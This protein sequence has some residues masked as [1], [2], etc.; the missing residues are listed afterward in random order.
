[1]TKISYDYRCVSKFRGM[2]M[3]IME[4][5]SH[6]IAF[7]RDSEKINNLVKESE[8]IEEVIDIIKNNSTI[9]NGR[10]KK[11]RYFFFVVDIDSNRY[12]LTS[13]LKIVSELEAQKKRFELYIEY[14]VNEIS[15][16][17]KKYIEYR[18]AMECK[19]VEEQIALLKHYLRRPLRRFKKWKKRPHAV[20][21]YH[22]YGEEPVKFVMDYD[23]NCI[24][25]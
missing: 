13:D 6:S 24:A 17:A 4:A 9:L 14:D 18:L 5:W 19:S 21:L 23:R 10:F 15:K 2:R 12:T 20:Y 8:N 22:T 11:F 25:E 1:M 16:E 7:K 3:T